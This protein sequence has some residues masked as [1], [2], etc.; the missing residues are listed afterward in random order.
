MFLKIKLKKIS[1]PGPGAFVLQSTTTRLKNSQLNVESDPP[2]PISI[3]SWEKELSFGGFE[4]AMCM[5]W[6]AS[7]TTEPQSFT[8][9]MCSQASLYNT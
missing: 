2:T 1:L 4:P 8:H 5:L 6:V 3:E 7:L 9:L